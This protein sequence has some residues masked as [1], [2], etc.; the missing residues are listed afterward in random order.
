MARSSGRRDLFLLFG[1]DSMTRGPCGVTGAWP[2]VSAAGFANICVYSPGICGAPP[3]AGI[4]GAGGIGRGVAN[5]CVALLEAGAGGAAGAG[6]GGGDGRAS[7]PKICVNSPA[8]F[9]WGG[10][11]GGVR[12]PM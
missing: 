3:D 11:G 12:E 4:I 9:G 5:T 1:T 7:R 6:A 10:V 2:N 8:P